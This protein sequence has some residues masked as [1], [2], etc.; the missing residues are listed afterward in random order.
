MRSSACTAVV[1]SLTA[2][3]SARIAMSTSMR[4]PKAGS[5]SI[6]RCRASTRTRRA[7]SS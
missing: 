5:W 4:S 7:R 1:G 6:V 3:E 2:G